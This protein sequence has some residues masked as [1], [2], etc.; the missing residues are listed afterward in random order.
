MVLPASAL[1]DFQP[2]AAGGCGQRMRQLC[3]ALGPRATG[4]RPGLHVGNCNGNGIVACLAIKPCF[5]SPLVWWRPPAVVGLCCR[6]CQATVGLH[7]AL[8]PGTYRYPTLKQV[9]ELTFTV[10]MQCH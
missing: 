3:Q 9:C 10:V 1:Y 2:V 7:G 5:C 6:W 8:L 4:W